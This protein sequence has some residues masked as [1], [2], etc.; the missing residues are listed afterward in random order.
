MP[1]A[2]PQMDLLPG[3][4][5]KTITG[6]FTAIKTNEFQDASL[7]HQVRELQ[8]QAGESAVCVFA[9]GAGQ[10]VVLSTSPDKQKQAIQVDFLPNG[11][12][13]GLGQISAGF[14]FKVV[15]NTTTIL[16]RDPDYQNLIPLDIVLAV[17][18]GHP[19][20]SI[21]QRLNGAGEG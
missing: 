15:G 14:S 10:E 3:E 1:V 13:N 9:L 17:Q 5:A 11:T 2:T 16:S 7:A 8:R 4:T 20:A 19:I 18:G 21:S 12:E 6:A